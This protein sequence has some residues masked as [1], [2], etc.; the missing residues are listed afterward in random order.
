MAST[1]NG[2]NLQET[3]YLWVVFVL[4]HLLITSC[5]SK[6]ITD[7]KHP[8]ILFIVADDL[9]Y[10]DL[11]CMGSE[12][13]ETPNI[14]KIAN[15]G[16][17]FTNGYATC[18]VCSPSRASLLTGKFP[19]RHGIT[20]WIGA[21]TG[22]DWRKSK[23]FTRLLPPSYV[24]HLPHEYH[25]W[26][27]VLKDHGYTT[28]FAGK[29]H[30]GSEG[31][32]PEDHGFDYNQ[33]GY[34]RGG[35]YTG[36]FFSPFNNPKMEDHPDEKGMSLS[37]KLARE[38]AAF[39]EANRDSQFLAYLSFYA[40]HA[41]IQTTQEKWAKYRNKALNSG[42]ADHGFE[43]ERVLPIRKFQDNPVY[44]GL[45]EQ[46]DEAVGHV[47]DVLEANNLSS[48]TIVVFTSDNGG[49]A[50]GDDFA[51]SNAPLRGGKGYQWEGGLKVPILV[52][53]P[54]LGGDGRTD[55]TPVTGADFYPTILDLLDIPL[56]P[57]Q[58]HDGQSFLP[59]LDGTA[60]KMT[61]PLYWHYPHYG[62]QGGEPSSVILRNDWKL[63]HYHED[64]R[65]E[66]YHLE[67]D[68]SEQR[69]ISKDHPD[70]LAELQAE[71]QDYLQSAGARFATNDPLFHPDSLQKKLDYYLHDLMPRLEQQRL[72][73]LRED[74]EPNADWWGSKVN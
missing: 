37:M 43:M 49:V 8:N 45:V 47:L 16:V 33:G 15:Q 35:P 17:V 25:T 21:R 64:D 39:V 70:L 44:A 65:K 73:F 24:D 32:Y 53:V 29:W 56:Q 2:N 69:D 5:Q 4:I 22:E 40:V 66:L 7:Q 6:S 51:T 26:P 50:S 30:L 68:P 42:I 19:A 13:Y 28:F 1:D 20:D 60:G 23:R 59:L 67:S 71:L 34:E 36:G 48:N 74:W 63:I 14:D 61:R 38:T 72:D 54:W 46:M 62:N 18:Q 58:H 3:L 11:S 57:D 55:P 9:G 31:S 27:E 52:H 41:P 10:H 12:Y